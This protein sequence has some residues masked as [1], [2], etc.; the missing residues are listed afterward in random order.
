MASLS[1]TGYKDPEWLYRTYTIKFDDGPI[2]DIREIGGEWAN[3]AGIV[4]DVIG[5][6]KRPIA[7]LFEGDVPRAELLEK[8]V[9]LHNDV[10]GEKRQAAYSVAQ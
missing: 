1:I 8:I 7:L 4:L 5:Q 6:T 2:S 3:L 9:S 10:Y